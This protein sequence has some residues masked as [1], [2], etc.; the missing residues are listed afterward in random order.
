MEKDCLGRKIEEVGNLHDKY[1]VSQ[2]TVTI[3]NALK[4]FQVDEAE[5]TI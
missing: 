2:L 3:P 1:A 5:K 4:T